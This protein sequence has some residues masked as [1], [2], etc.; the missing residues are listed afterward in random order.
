MR[1]GKPVTTAMIAGI[2]VEPEDPPVVTESRVVAVKSAD[3]VELDDGTEVRLLS[4]DIPSNDDLQDAAM[5][6][7]HELMLG[8]TVR[9]ERDRKDTDAEGRLQ[10]YAHVDGVNVNL[11]LVR[12]GLAFHN[13]SS[14]NF[15]YA[16]QLIVAGIDAMR[17]KFGFWEE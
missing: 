2:P 4:V 5:S 10:R 14:P 13:V 3:T 11:D 16:E 6:R 12:H 9:L 1:S 15:K 8:R 17:H 7:L